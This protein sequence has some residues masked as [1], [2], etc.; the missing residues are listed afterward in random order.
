MVLGDEGDIALLLTGYVGSKDDGQP[1][2]QGFTDGA[3]ACFGDDDIGGPHHL[4]HV[5]HEAEDSGGDAQAG[6]YALQKRVELFI[7]TGDDQQ[8]RG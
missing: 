4:R 3:R 5:L 2:G 7:A 8:L 1:A 6:T